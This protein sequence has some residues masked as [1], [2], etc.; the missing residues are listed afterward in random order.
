MVADHQSGGHQSGMKP[1]KSCSIN[2]DMRRQQPRPS[3]KHRSNAMLK[4]PRRQFLQLAAGTAA[5]AGVTRIARAQT[6][7][8]RPVRIIV[9]FPA[10]GPVD[11]VARLVAQQLSERVG[12][13]FFVENRSG[14][15]GI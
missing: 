10:G 7:P 2:R 3:K 12:R 1:A 13:Q 14:A 6:Y 11:S 9:A 5:L 4:L 15:G 8:T